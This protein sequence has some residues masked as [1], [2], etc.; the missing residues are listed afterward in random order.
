M[1]RT[2]WLHHQR[3]PASARFLFEFT[4]F[5]TFQREGQAL[6]V[7][8]HCEVRMGQQIYIIIIKAGEHEHCGNAAIYL[9]L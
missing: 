7:E 5:M 1:K 2:V 4:F 9:Y 3:N 8:I 6:R